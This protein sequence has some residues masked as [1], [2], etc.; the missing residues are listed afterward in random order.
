M[1]FEHECNIRI[2]VLKWKKY[3]RSYLLLILIY[4]LQSSHFP[5]TDYFP[6]EFLLYLNYIQ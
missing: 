1:E 3:S 2:N 6:S 5:F 4:L